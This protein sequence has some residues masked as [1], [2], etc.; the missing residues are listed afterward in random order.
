[1]DTENLIDRFIDALMTNDNSINRYDLLNKLIQQNIEPN[2]LN[3]LI[4]MILQT[5]PIFTPEERKNLYDNIRIHLEH[6]T[7][8]YFII[9]NYISDQ[10]TP[11]EKTLLGI[12][13]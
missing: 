12:S 10:M 11:E 8:I 6:N 1:M 13:L 2:H 7:E 3:F 9:F 5:E 4:D